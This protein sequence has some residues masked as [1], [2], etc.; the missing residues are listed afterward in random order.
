MKTSRGHGGV[1]EPKD[2]VGAAEVA[3]FRAKAE[4]FRRVASTVKPGF[5]HPAAIIRS[6]ERLAGDFEERAFE[7][8]RELKAL[9]THRK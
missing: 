5:L 7:V 6:L 4:Y 3:Y 9:H 2:Q 8:E 1:Y